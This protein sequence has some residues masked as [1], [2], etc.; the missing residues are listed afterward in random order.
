MPK[1]EATFVT[2]INNRIDRDLHRQS[3]YTP[4]SS[5]TPDCYYEA[6]HKALWVEYKF[7]RQMPGIYRLSK[8]VSSLQIIW[9]NRAYLNGINVY[10]VTGFGKHDVVVFADMTWEND[11]TRE[12]LLPHVIPR[13]DFIKN[14]NAFMNGGT[15]VLGSTDL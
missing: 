15:M 11:Y 4:Y 5:G 6:K 13:A 2:Y 7:E 8:K 10:V 12:E 3:M 9:L 1:P 14:L